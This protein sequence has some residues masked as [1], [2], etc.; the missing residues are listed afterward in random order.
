MPSL[1]LAKL[2]IVVAHLVSWRN[3]GLKKQHPLSISIRLGSFQRS[4]ETRA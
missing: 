4:G 1:S 2:E 3:Q